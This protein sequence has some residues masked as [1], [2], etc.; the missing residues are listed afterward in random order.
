MANNKKVIKRLK[1]YRAKFAVNDRSSDNMLSFLAFIEN[2]FGKESNEVRTFRAFKGN[3]KDFSYIVEFI[4]GFIQSVQDRELFKRNDRHNFL[5]NLNNIE[6]TGWITGGA[7]SI[8]MS[9]FYLTSLYK[10]IMNQSETNN[11][12]EVVRIQNDSI[13]SLRKA[14]KI[15]PQSKAKYQDTSANK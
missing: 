12:K 7:L 6:L 2:Y 10:D 9:T 11:L 8:I 1:E 3:V 14:A 13:A 5:W 15:S 4:D